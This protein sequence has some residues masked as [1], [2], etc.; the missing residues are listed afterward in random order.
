LGYDGKW[1]VHP[2]QLKSIN[3]SFTPND[4]DIR[5]AWR[6]MEAY[7]KARASG[8]GVTALDGK[9]VDAASVRA[10]RITY[11]KAKRLGLL[12]HVQAQ[13]EPSGD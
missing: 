10:A 2:A 5:R 6:I 13:L 11:L 3:E 7:E 9:M 12:T 8:A 1:A 4:K